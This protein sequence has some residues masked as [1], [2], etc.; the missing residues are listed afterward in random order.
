[1][2]D[3]CLKWIAQPIAI[4]RA[5]RIAATVVAPTRARTRSADTRRRRACPLARRVRRRDAGR[6]RQARS[7]NVEPTPSWL[8]TYAAPPIASASSRTIASP[9]PVPTR[10]PLSLPLVE[11]EALE[12]VREVAAPR[13]PARRRRP[14]R[15]PGPRGCARSRRD[16]VERSAFSTR[17]ESACRSRSGSASA[18]ASGV[19]EHLR[20]RRRSAARPPRG[21]RTRRATTLTEVDRLRA[22]R[23]GAPAQAGE[24]EQVADEPLEPPRLALDHRCRPR[25]ARARRPR[26]PPRGL[27]SR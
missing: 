21:A 15:G 13:A 26:A 11:I 6:D 27:G 4:V 23:E 17:F 8:R 7:P 22:H 16:G 24:V 5:S 9:R 25:P 14:R 19:G 20:A 1:M 18:T 12:G 2:R 3:S 10:R